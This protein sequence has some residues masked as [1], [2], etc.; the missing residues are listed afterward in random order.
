[1]PTLT[2]AHSPKYLSINGDAISLIVKFEEFET[3]VHFNA[4]TY[5]SY[6]HGRDIHARALAGEFGVIAPYSPPV[7]PPATEPQPDATGTQTL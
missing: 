4:T 5:D 7:A 1:M 2:N 6:E 3:E